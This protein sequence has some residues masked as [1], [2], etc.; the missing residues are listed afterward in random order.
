M[1]FF[2]LLMFCFWCFCFCRFFLM[3]LGF[4]VCCF[5]FLLMFFVS[6]VFV[7]IAIL[8]FFVFVAAVFVFAVF[9]VIAVF[10]AV[11]VA[12]KPVSVAAHH[13]DSRPLAASQR[14]TQR[15]VPTD[16]SA[17]HHMVPPPASQRHTQHPVST[18][19]STPSNMVPRLRLRGQA[20][21]RQQPYPS[22]NGSLNQPYVSET[23]PQRPVHSRQQEVLLGLPSRHM[24]G[25]YKKE[26]HTRVHPKYSGLVPPSIQQLW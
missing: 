13:A 2:V 7:F 12:N 24:G 14:H 22:N 4:C 16:N 18:D 3:F 10:V 6:A 21:A 17:P 1:L 23:A 9:V 11:A 25:K 8:L 26:L 5:L 19:S 15:P 20:S